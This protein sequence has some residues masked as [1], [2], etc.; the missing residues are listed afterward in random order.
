MGRSN[1]QGVLK[2]LLLA[3]CFL[4]IDPTWAWLKQ[5]QES[6]VCSTHRPSLLHVRRLE[7]L[8]HVRINYILNRP[9]NSCLTK[10][11]GEYFQMFKVCER[12][13]RTIMLAKLIN[14]FLAWLFPNRKSKLALFIEDAEIK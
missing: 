9:L 11:C 2:I 3:K 6:L 4:V 10:I 8:C 7:I 1:H 12:N 13:V 5:P 14:F